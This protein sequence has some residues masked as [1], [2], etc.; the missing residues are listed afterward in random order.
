MSPD[1]L[2]AA[3]AYAGH[4]WPVFP[5]RGKLP[6]HPKSA[7][8][9][10]FH[11]ATTDP[12]VVQR[13]WRVYP[14]ANVGIRTGQLSGLAVLDVDPAHGGSDSLARVEAERGILPGTVMQNTGGGGLHMLYRWAPG[15]G[16][17]ANVWGPGLD[18]RAEG[19]YI[20]AA[21]STHPDTGQP[22]AWHGGEWAHDLPAWPLDVLPANRQPAERPVVVPFRADAG[23]TP[24][25]RGGPLAGLV[26]TVLNAQ[27]GQRNVTLNWAAFRAGEHVA[28]GRLDA[29]TAASAL[30]AAAAAIGLSEREAIR[31]I[32][33][34]LGSAG[35]A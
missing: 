1:P 23:Q 5:L 8:G 24:T 15:L 35:A 20:V 14:G 10:G 31:T 32:G 4:G 25:D 19:G 33:S 17:G 6:A 34:G 12:A 7:G 30:L 27:P 26:R 11:D 22:Y 16:C 3:H 21:P 2:A 18:L 28:R 13:M 29:T 9:R